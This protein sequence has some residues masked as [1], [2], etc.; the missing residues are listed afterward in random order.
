MSGLL[1]GF[2]NG[3]DTTDGIGGK[4]G[5]YDEKKIEPIEVKPEKLHLSFSEYTL[6]K[7]CP[8]KW[9]LQYV[10]DK[11][12]PTNFKKE[13]GFRYKVKNQNG[14]N[15][16]LYDF[17][18]PEN[19]GRT[20]IDIRKA[21][22][23]YPIKYPCKIFIIDQMFECRKIYLDIEYYNWIFAKLNKLWF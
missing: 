2:N 12:E 13:T 6:Y 3:R 11:K 5:Y 16:A 9:F 19:N 8:F 1:N 7:S 14:L 17:Y 18:D 4:P 22:E 20:K 10:L 15:N 21:L 23:N